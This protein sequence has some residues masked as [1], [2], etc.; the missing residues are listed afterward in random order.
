VAVL[1]DAVED[2]P[3]LVEELRRAGYSEDVCSSVADLT[4][5]KDELYEEYI[6]RT[7]TNPIAIRVKLADLTD[8]MNPRRLLAG[9]EADERRLARY[10]LAYRRLTTAQPL[11]DRPGPGSLDLERG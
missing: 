9:D 11:P 1:H 2:T 6:E 5:S 4:R 7:T 3:L 10:Q 8:N